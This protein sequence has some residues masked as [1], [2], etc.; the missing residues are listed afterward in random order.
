MQE[1]ERGTRDEKWQ[2][3]AQKWQ[4]RISQRNLL[5]MLHDNCFCWG[6]LFD[7]CVSGAP[8]DVP[9]HDGSIWPVLFQTTSGP[10]RLYDWRLQSPEVSEKGP[11]ILSSLVPFHCHTLSDTG[12]NSAPSA[13]HQK[14]PYR[15]STFDP[16]PTSVRVWKFYIHSWG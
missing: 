13:C 2:L 7:S 10:Q 1:V 11:V 6:N 4:V 14:L 5:K 16:C 15:L 9:L 12:I 8:T 3:P